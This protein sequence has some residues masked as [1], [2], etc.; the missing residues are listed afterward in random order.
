MAFPV[1]ATFKPAPDGTVFIVS[2]G[3]TRNWMVSNTSP[4]VMPATMT[5]FQPCSG[6]SRS[7]SRAT[8]TM[9]QSIGSS[10]WSNR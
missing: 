4:A 9:P 10:A 5:A 8:A 3:P 6:T 2:G 7:I 1:T